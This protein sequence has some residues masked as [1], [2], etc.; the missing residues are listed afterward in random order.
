M[1]LAY[2]KRQIWCLVLGVFSLRHLLDSQVDVSSWPRVIGT[3]TLF[4]IPRLDGFSEGVG[5]R[6]GEELHALKLEAALTFGA[7]GYEEEP[8]GNSV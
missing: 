1:W 8:Q 4:D 5:D 6:G 3:W 2:L 7:Q